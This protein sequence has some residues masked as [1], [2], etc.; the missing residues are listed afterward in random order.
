[1]I[2]QPGIL[3]L[4][5]ASIIITLLVLYAGWYGLRILLKW[6]IASGSELQLTLERRTYL[7]ATILSYCLAFQI[8]SLF[9]FIYTADS[10]HVLF[11]GAMCAAG[12][13]NV[14]PYGYP[15]L[16]LKIGNCLL[17]GVWLIVN[18]ADTRGYDYPLIRFKYALLLALAPLIVLETFLQFRYFAGL[19]PDII[20]SCCG[21]LFSIDR[22]SL[23]GDLAALPARPMEIAFYASMGMSIL[24]GGY[25]YLKRK[26]GYL[27]AAASAGTLVVAVASLVSFICLYFYQLPTHHCPFCILQKEYGHVGYVLYAAL[28]GG[29]V[30]GLGVGALMPFRRRGSM[31]RIIPPLQRRLTA[32][33]VLLYLLFTLIVTWR[34]L[35]T[36]FRLGG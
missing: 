35:T 32:T 31:V 5:S 22:A 34:I 33:T 9:L 6:N 2:L 1:M 7:I 11:T 14:N 25:F 12:T 10:L 28:F 29:G 3:A 23:S 19:T 17:A 18:H 21:S 26:G 4:V 24:C 8:V 36:S 30:A 13:L 16:L 15:V 27:F 20:T